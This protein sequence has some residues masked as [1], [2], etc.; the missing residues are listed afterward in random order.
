MH[1]SK[2]RLKQHTPRPCDFPLLSHTSHQAH[3]GCAGEACAQIHPEHPQH[4]H[5]EEDKDKDKDKDIDHSAAWAG[6]VEVVDE[7]GGQQIESSGDGVNNNTTDHSAPRSLGTRDLVD[8][9]WRDVLVQP[10]PRSVAAAVAAAAQWVKVEASDA[11]NI[12]E[13]KDAHGACKALGSAHT[14]RVPRDYTSWHA[15]KAA[16]ERK[17]S[18]RTR[19]DTKLRKN[20]RHLTA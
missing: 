11:A 10:P 6:W 5:A 3:S 8:R 13:P 4:E 1:H 16:G 2:Q 15:I 9:A 14:V 12:G 20:R 19:K 17:V 7:D 18:M